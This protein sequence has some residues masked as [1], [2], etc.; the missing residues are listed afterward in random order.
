MGREFP[1]CK[2]NRILE[3]DGGDS[4]TGMSSPFMLVRRTLKNGYKG[5][6]YIYFAIVFRKGI[7]FLKL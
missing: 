5:K 4:R 6:F 3:M 2:M 7:I 1:F